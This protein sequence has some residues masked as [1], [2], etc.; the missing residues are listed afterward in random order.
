MKASN[1]HLTIEPTWP[2]AT[3]CV[4]RL[5]GE[6]DI[7]AVGEADAAVTLAQMSGAESLVLDLRE[8]QLIDSAGLRLLLE[9]EER[10]RKAGM[11]FA[12]V[13]DEGSVVRR[14]LDLTFLT[15]RMPVLDDPAG[16]P[17]GSRGTARGGSGA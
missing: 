16:A 10:A 9:G 14:M 13:A 6:L 11:S 1:D 17:A 4:L 2:T 15:A 8:L 7:A 3:S 12:V 5:L